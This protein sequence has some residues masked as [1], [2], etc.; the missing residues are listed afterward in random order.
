MNKKFLLVLDD[1]WN[2]QDETAWDNVM[3]LLRY[4]RSRS[5]IFLTTRMR[6]VVE[7]VGWSVA[8][9]MSEP[10]NLKGLEENDYLMLFN[11]YAFG[12]ANPGN[13]KKLQ[14][15]AKEIPKKL[16]GI[17]LAAKT[18]GGILRKELSDEHWTRILEGQLIRTGK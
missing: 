3:A 6:L 7:M 4:G 14:I 5:K 8:G 12:G 13:H 1:V 9:E 18:I 2:D 11:K 17:P 10:L 16:R 15:I